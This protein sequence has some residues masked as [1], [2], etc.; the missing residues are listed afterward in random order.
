MREER[1]ETDRTQ[2]FYDRIS[3][4]YDLIAD[5]SEHAA[6]DLGIRALGVCRGQRALEIGCGTGHGL[7]SLADAVGPT[8][9]VY[10][11][12]I[13]PGMM[14]V[15]HLR[16][17][18]AHLPNVVLTIGDASALCFRSN[19]FDAV[20]MSFT[21]ELF[22]STMPTVL[23]EV[24]RVLRTDGR[25]GIVAMAETG[26]TNA[27]IDL[28]EWLHRHWPHFIDCRPIDVAG[29]LQA[30]GFQASTPHATTIWSLPVV[31]AVG[32]KTPHDSEEDRMP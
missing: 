7:I 12:D 27:M 16:V 22:E 31:A 3:R 25:V 26:Q 28:Y 21:L 6:R 9:V 1:S 2:R 17:R 32:F 14:A 15:A 8:G 4:A 10:G 13:S 23:A 29:R 20:F 30:A 24:W 18:S 5:S 19:V 11:V